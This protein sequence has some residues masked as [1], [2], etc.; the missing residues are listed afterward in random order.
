LTNQ[1]LD[2]ESKLER[3]E[4]LEAANQVAVLVFARINDKK[5]ES[6]VQFIFPEVKNNLHLSFV[7]NKGLIFHKEDV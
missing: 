2:L 1:H 6:G 4:I 3:Q 5:L 7:R